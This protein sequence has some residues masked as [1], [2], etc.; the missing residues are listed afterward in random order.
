MAC[1]GVEVRWHVPLAGFVDW[2]LSR[3]PGPGCDPI[4]V[5]VRAPDGTPLVSLPLGCASTFSEG[6]DEDRIVAVTADAPAAY[7]LVFEGY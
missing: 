4:R 6:I 7:G 2:T 5:D 1:P 3:D